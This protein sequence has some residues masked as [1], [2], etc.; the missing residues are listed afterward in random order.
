MELPDDH[1][2]GARTPAR[3]RRHETAYPDVLA[4]L[5]AGRARAR[6][7]TTTSTPRGSS[8]GPARR[9]SS[10][11]CRTTSLHVGLIQLILPNARIIDARRH[12]LACCFSGVQAAFRPRPDL[13]LRPR[14]PRPLLPRLRG[15]D[16]ALRRGAARPRPP[17]DLRA[18]WS[19]TP[20][21]RCGAC[22][23]TAGCRSRTACLRF[24]ENARAVRTASSEQVRQPIFR[25]GLDQWQCYEAW[26]A[27]LRDALGP[28]LSDYPKFP[29]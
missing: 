28:A 11:R 4:E 19:T 20:R 9:C 7:A 17:G 23:S 8:A 21:A 10:T 15:A 27:P 29:G 1:R 26:L 3:P 24:Y 14:R 2:D 13:H 18:A 25:Q 6:S 5:V 12:P 22:S 16:G